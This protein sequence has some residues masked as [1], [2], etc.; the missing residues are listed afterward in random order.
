MSIEQDDN[1][2]VGSVRKN[3]QFQYKARNAFSPNVIVDRFLSRIKK[4]FQQW[5]AGD[6]GG[7]SGRAKTII[8]RIDVL[9][10]QLSSFEA[11]KATSDSAKSIFIQYIVNPLLREGAKLRA[12]ILA[13]REPINHQL[14]SHYILWI[15]RSYR[16][17]D[18]FYNKSQKE[19]Y[20]DVVDHIIKETG[21]HVQKDVKLIYDYIDQQIDNLDVPDRKVKEISMAISES[22]EKHLTKLKSIEIRLPKSREATCVQQWRHDTDILRQK[23]FGQCLEMIDKILQENLPKPDSKNV[24]VHLVKA[25][26]KIISLEDSIREVIYP[27][28]PLSSEVAEKHLKRKIAALHQQAHKISL[29]IRL[30]QELFDRVQE[31]MAALIKRYEQL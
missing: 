6:N 2:A 17:I 15:D 26:D 3:E 22:L 18:S 31:M 29:D 21:S 20:N 14:T 24:Q 13:A 30:S 1:K 10:D 12:D 9:I 16:W 27:A 11:S 4:T 28:E 25:L 7:L 8:P 5:N 19:L 23:L